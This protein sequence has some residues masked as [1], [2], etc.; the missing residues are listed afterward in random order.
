MT[1]HAHGAVE[2]Y[3]NMNDQWMYSKLIKHVRMSCESAE[4]F[5]SLFSDFYARCQKPKETKDQ[6]EDELQVLAR[7][8][9]T[10]HLPVEAQDE[11]G[12]ENIVCS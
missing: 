7:Q 1:E 5:S 6:F 10:V 4:T 2:F 11:Q 9:I 8:I 3:L 12:T